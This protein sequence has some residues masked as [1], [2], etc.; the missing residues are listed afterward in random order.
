MK[1]RGSDLGRGNA[2]LGAAETGAGEG[3]VGRL[4][5]V[6]VK[7]RDL[8]LQLRGEQTKKAGR[9]LTGVTRY[10][11]ISF[12]PAAWSARPTRDLNDMWKGLTC[13]KGAGRAAAPTMPSGT[14]LP[15]LK[16]PLKMC[17]TMSYSKKTDPLPADVNCTKTAW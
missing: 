15:R 7:G 12:H 13:E 17:K 11:T 1:Y 14:F 2:S 16:T 4:L 8:G 3:R 5:P 6:L 10:L 9:S